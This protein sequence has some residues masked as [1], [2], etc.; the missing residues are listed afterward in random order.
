MSTMTIEL[1]R[2]ARVD[3]TGGDITIALGRDDDDL[4]VEIILA[5]HHDALARLHEALGEMLSGIRVFWPATT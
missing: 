4:A 3:I 5:G 1:S 2:D